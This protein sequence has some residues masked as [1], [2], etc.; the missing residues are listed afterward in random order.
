[1]L[2]FINVYNTGNLCHLINPFFVTNILL[3]HRNQ[4]KKTAPKNINITNWIFDES[5]KWPNYVYKICKWKLI[6]EE[7]APHNFQQ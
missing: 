4:L 5:K 2:N 6:N 1:M 7:I 3:Q